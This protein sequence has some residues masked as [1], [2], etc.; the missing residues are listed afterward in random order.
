[1]FLEWFLGDALKYGFFITR[2]IYVLAS[3][4]KQYNSQFKYQNLPVS[5]REMC[6]YLQHFC[7]QHVSIID[8]CTDTNRHLIKLKKRPSPIYST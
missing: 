5:S 2:E 1:M 8:V 3:E 6:L 7:K 4:N